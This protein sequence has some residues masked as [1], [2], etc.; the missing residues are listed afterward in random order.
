MS[1]D[2]LNPKRAPT[3]TTDVAC[4]EA[5]MPQ[6]PTEIMLKI[7]RYLD[8]PTALEAMQ[9]NSVLR[10]CVRTSTV[11]NFKQSFRKLLEQVSPHLT[12]E[13]N[14]LLSELIEDFRDNIQI[15]P[16]LPPVPFDTKEA[17]AVLRREL[18]QY[19]A[20]SPTAL[21]RNNP[22]S[23]VNLNPPLA[24]PDEFEHILQLGVTIQNVQAIQNEP[25]EQP[26]FQRIYN[27]FY[28]TMNYKPSACYMRDAVKLLSPTV[29][30]ILTT[31]CLSST[32]DFLIMELIPHLPA[33][34]QLEALIFIKKWN[35]AF[36][37]LE[38][39]ENPA[40][41]NELFRY[42]INTLTNR[43]VDRDYSKEHERLK[44]ILDC[45][46]RNSDILLPL[47]RLKVRSDLPAVSKS[48][49]RLEPI[50]VEPFIEKALAI[51]Q[52]AITTKNFDLA[53]DMAMLLPAEIGLYDQVIEEYKKSRGDAGDY[54]KM[55]EFKNY[56]DNWL[57]TEKN[58]SKL[59][60]STVLENIDRFEGSFIKS[61]NFCFPNLA[62][63][64]KNFAYIA[65]F[66]SL[67]N[68]M[69][70]E[71]LLEMLAS[72][73]NTP[74]ENE[75]PPSIWRLALTQDEGWKPFF[76]KFPHLIHCPSTRIW[77]TFMIK[78]VPLELRTEVLGPLAENWFSDDSETYLFVLDELQGGAIVEQAVPS[79]VIEQLVPAEYRELEIKARAFAKAQ[80]QLSNV[81]N[82]RQELRNYGNNLME[83]FLKSG[84]ESVKA[85]LQN[86][87]LTPAQKRLGKIA[88]ELFQL[89]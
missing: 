15:S 71:N 53:M 81:M 49:Y 79:N 44:A 68:E 13:Q 14:V 17:R 50:T 12:A 55:L 64:Q 54:I 48:L 88:I 74:P 65:V 19:L 30:K 52:K 60:S 85:L 31:T 46:E 80:R 8:K 77:S 87:E 35:E 57:D 83:T 20:E 41:K 18:I 22:T 76:S 1:T 29:S 70:F 42:L 21:D 78:N 5:T 3:L 26:L 34:E 73:P 51:A 2:P 62:D 56:H 7:V 9:V 38:S 59:I 10:A 58:L 36:I 40:D 69:K 67:L 86:E 25:N 72:F 89:I 37:V 63:E 24:L 66:D 16:S 39:I 84:L 75:A 47:E 28:H 23:L 61:F 6:L 45:L 82:L 11:S 33:K 4:P 27:M 43:F 32:Q